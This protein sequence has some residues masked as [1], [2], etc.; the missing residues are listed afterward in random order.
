MPSRAFPELVPH[1]EL[2]EVLH[3]LDASGMSQRVI[4]AAADIIKLHSRGLDRRQL[5]ADFLVR[6]AASRAPDS[7]VAEGFGILCGCRHRLAAS[8]R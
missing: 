2:I 4:H 7:D 3:K 5:P 8:H 6:L 1:I